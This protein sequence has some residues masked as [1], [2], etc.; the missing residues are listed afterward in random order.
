MPVKKDASGKRWVE[1][2]VLVS[3]SPD[4][5]WRALATGPGYAAWFTK[6]RIE[7]RVGG[8][9]EFH[10]GPDAKSTGQVTFWEPPYVFGYVERDWAEGAPPVATEVT[11][12]SRSGGQ[13]VVR[14]VHS[15]FASSDDWDDQLEGFE[16]GWPG[17]F[18]VLRIYLAHF[19]GMEADQAGAMVMGVQEEPLT[20]WTRLTEGLGLAG[21]NVGERR[22]TSPRPEALTGTVESIVQ[23]P[24][25]RYILLRL[26][27]PVPGVA[28]CGTHAV[29][30]G[31]HVSASF[32]FYGPGA[33]KQASTSEPLWRNWFAELFPARA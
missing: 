33:A 8:E 28:L 15:L 1:M 6:A 4:E 2:E 31:V 25:S 26:E 29:K 13:C 20:V 9:L 24:K 3:G 30:D 11:I 21:A 10:F 32:F 22:T 16:G 17:F 5:V 7:E 14:M 27:A 23:N 19:T 18:E 12:T